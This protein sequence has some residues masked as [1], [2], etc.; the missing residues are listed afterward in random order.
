MKLYNI[1]IVVVVLPE[2]RSWNNKR[3]LLADWKLRNY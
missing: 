3:D 1:H 2:P